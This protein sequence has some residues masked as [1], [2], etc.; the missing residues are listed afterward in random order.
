LGKSKKK[1]LDQENNLES[2]HLG[3]RARSSIIKSPFPPRENFSFFLEFK[4][5]YMRLGASYLEVERER[6]IAV[7]SCLLA[8]ASELEFFSYF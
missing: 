1:V 2:H 7:A 6:E 5:K 3:R 4:E 8:F